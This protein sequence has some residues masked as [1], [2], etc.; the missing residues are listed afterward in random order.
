MES[1]T[2]FG[3]HL[4]GA[5]KVTQ[6]W[7][8]SLHPRCSEHKSSMS[9]QMQFM[10]IS[11]PGE[12]CLQVL[13]LFPISYRASGEPLNLSEPQVCVLSRFGCAPLFVTPGTAARQ[14]PLS[15]GFSRQEYCGGL[16]C[17]PQGIFP[18][19]GWNP[20]LLHLLHWQGRSLSLASPR[21]PLNPRLAT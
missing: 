11:T 16:P 18:T 2:G 15:V 4:M 19:Q 8:T 13:R 3:R 20:S 9:L 12:T 6:G 5:R 17:P 7:P 1:F 14:A 21:K 10:Q